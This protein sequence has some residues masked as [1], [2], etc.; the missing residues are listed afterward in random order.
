MY[1]CAGV[2]FGVDVSSVCERVRCVIYY[3]TVHFI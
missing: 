1:V 2:F 3:V